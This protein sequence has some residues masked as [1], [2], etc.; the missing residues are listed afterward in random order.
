METKPLASEVSKAP[1]SKRNQN[2]YKKYMKLNPNFADGTT[3]ACISR[4][5]ISLTLK[6]LISKYFS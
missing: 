2:L 6:S 1:K 5:S 4:M 3:I